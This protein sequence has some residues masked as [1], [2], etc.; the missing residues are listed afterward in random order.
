MATTTAKAL[1][2]RARKAGERSAEVATELKLNTVLQNDLKLPS[3]ER[4]KLP[5]PVHI[6]ERR[7]VVAHKSRVREPSFDG[8]NG[9][10]YQP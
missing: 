9:F 5:Y 1:N 7:A 2:R 3:L 6:H 8:R 10:S 4:A